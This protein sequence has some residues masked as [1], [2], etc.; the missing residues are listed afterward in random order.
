[1]ANLD[2]TFLG[3]SAAMPSE[4]RFLS[5]VVINRNGS[6]FIFDAGEGMQYNFIR[7][8]FGF[9]KK[10]M[11]FITHMHSDHILGLLGFFQ[12]LSLQGRNLPIDIYGPKSLYDFLIENIKILDIH[13]S[14]NLNIHIISESEGVLVV[15]KDYKIMFCRSNHGHGISSYAYCLVEDS[16]PGEFDVKKAKDLGIPAGILYQK[17]QK[18]ENITFNNKLIPSN[19]IVGPLR[20][21]RKIGISGDTRPTEELCKFFQDCDLLIFE[22]TFSSTEL[23]KAKESFHSTAYEAANLAKIS[24][25]HRLCLTHFSTRYKDLTALLNEAKSVFKE[26]DLAYDLK[27]ISVP[28]RG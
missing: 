23:D 22:S 21:G 17:L 9:N 27:S 12:T 15:D 6:L 10:T 8:R 16:R 11:L 28:Y 13:F 20:P 24:I 7:G 19:T 14:F 4:N 1:M 18:G 5:S 3:T 26:V 2:V 25:V